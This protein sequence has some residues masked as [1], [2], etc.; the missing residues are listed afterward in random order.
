METC[1]GKFR[2]PLR[3]WWCLRSYLHYVSFETI[4]QNDNNI[5]QSSLATEGSDLGYASASAASV[6]IV[7]A[8]RVVLLS[9]DCKASF[10]V[11]TRCTRC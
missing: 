11:D 1:E 8:Q 2:E 10:D 9:W 6:T 7:A 3:H 4:N 5:M